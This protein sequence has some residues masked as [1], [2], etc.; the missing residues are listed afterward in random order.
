MKPTPIFISHL[1][2][3]HIQK[4]KNF[5]RVGYKILKF[6]LHYNRMTLKRTGLDKTNSVLHNYR[7]GFSRPYASNYFPQ[8][9]LFMLL[10]LGILEGLS[11]FL[12]QILAMSYQCG[13]VHFKM[14]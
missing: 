10:Q 5:K 1:G 13:D 14:V 4:Q 6:C 11:S 3:Q 7:L 2:L 9:S 12:Y 8:I